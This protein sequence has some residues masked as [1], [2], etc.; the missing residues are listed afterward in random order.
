MDDGD[1]NAVGACGAVDAELIGSRSL[2][3]GGGKTLLLLSRASL[4]LFLLLLS[5]L[6]MDSD[7]DLVGG[8]N[9]LSDFKPA[10]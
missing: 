5:F 1:G 2:V 8:G 10:G 6:G 7:F 3:D 9:P 4:S